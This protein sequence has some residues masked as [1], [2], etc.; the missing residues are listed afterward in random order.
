VPGTETLDR[1]SR[2]HALISG[3]ESSTAP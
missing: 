2:L 1:L 3:G